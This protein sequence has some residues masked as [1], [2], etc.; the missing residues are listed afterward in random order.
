ME[1]NGQPN[2]RSSRKKISDRDFV[3]ISLGLILLAFVIVAGTG[4]TIAGDFLAYCLAYLFG[5]FY[6][7]ILALVVVIAFRL[8]FFRRL[9]SLKGKGLLFSG[10]I[11]LTFSL[12]A[13]GSYSLFAQREGGVPFSDLAVV[14]ND[15]FQSFARYPF[16]IDS[17][18]ALGGL[19]GGFIGIF[20][21]TLFGSLW[22]EVGDAVFFSLLVAI[23][24]V[25]ILFKPIR[26]M[27]NMIQE[28]RRKRVAYK[29]P[30]QPNKKG[31]NP[32]LDRKINQDPM[33]VESEPNPSLHAPFDNSSWANTSATSSSA[34]FVSSDGSYYQPDSEKDE[35]SS[36]T[37]AS[38]NASPLSDDI[39]KQE[40]SQPQEKEPEEEPFVQ[41]SPFT[42]TSPAPKR[43]QKAFTASE[44]R[45][46]SQQP[47]A[48]PAPQPNPQPY[49][50]PTPVQQP[51]GPAFVSTSPT[52]QQTTSAFT[53]TT[54]IPQPQAQPY[55]APAPQPQPHTYVAPTPVQQPTAPVS[56]PLPQ[57]EPSVTP[58]NAPSFNPLEQVASASHPV[59]APQASKEVAVQSAAPAPS[60]V[61]TPI[62]AP[63]PAPEAPKEEE[64][65]EEEIENRKAADYFAKKQQAKMAALQ[66]K[67]KEH[68]EKLA[69]LMRFVS[70]TPR[71]YSYPLPN[72]SMLA[73][74]DDS[75]KMAINTESAQE[76][77]TI[78]NRVFDEFDVHAKATTFT[79]GASVT[80]FN[81]ETE[82]G[83]KADKIA[84]LTSEFQRALN[85]D[86]SVR[87]ETVVEGR[88]TSGI[89][90]GN[91]AP[92]AVSFKDVFSQIEQNTKDPLLLPIGKDISGNI[93][94]FPLNKM[95]HL[96]VAGTTGSGKSVLIHSMIMTLIMRNYPSQL[97]LM[98]IDPK[99][100]EFI[101]YQE[102]SHLFCPVISKPESAI[103]ALKKLCAEMDRR[104]SILSRYK[105]ANLEDYNALRRGRENEMEQM[106]YI[107]CI[108]DEFA[109]LMQTG[110]N[111][112]ERNVTRLAQKARA[113]G[114]HLI[115]ATQRPSKDNVPMIIKAN[116]PSRIG[117]SVSSQIDSRVILDENGAETL[118]G[119]GDLLFKCPGK[120]SLIRAQ[121]PF[122][123]NED[124]NNILAYIKEKAG[125]P[126]YNQE[127]L[128]LDE[129]AAP[130]EDEG[131]NEEGDLYD[132]IKDFVTSTG[133]TSKSALMRSFQISSAKADQFFSRLVQDG[134]I[135][136]GP[137][138]K[139]V[140]STWEE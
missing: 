89:E 129:A 6:P 73:E 50:A 40:A 63:A 107:V 55:V 67:K 122:V 23:A 119:R 45:P 30:Y 130:S 105:T 32:H 19:G 133:I 57:P 81:I 139:Y 96:L 126:V 117:L 91:K 16:H 75:A 69:S 66:E 9:W 88:S 65:S 83:E 64:L 109:D 68:D 86:M 70:D 38:E 87:V 77:A 112:V 24:L 62:V 51:T 33:A 125:D 97:K 4:K 8:I 46:V 29:S 98:L 49:V 14:Y 47:Q 11:L 21:V 7:F 104:F 140:V 134:V 101:R 120:K 44:N 28:A 135:H 78:I 132:D 5:L 93:V 138:G 124:I 121:S 137:E 18:D 12:L 42:Q 103:L 25:L 106:P 48:N 41:A 22:G 127:F 27:V 110:G 90:V 60:E 113:C 17:F 72:D 116:V 102:C 76:K 80:R 1:S 3:L 128:D 123:S 56:Q 118:L 39:L 95:P 94:S 2:N 108:I 36:F 58:A 92:M 114:I 15:R 31:T 10:C 52:P 84:S 136:L 43:E 54:P 79:I 115:I 26:T 71:T 99:Q 111:E 37:P 74:V 131:E 20:L 34:A 59:M 53:A 85:G 61:A 13:F 35:N 100:V 82:H